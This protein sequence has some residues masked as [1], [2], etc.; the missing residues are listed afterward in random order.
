M[1]LSRA[2]V[3]ALMILA[4]TAN[5]AAATGGRVTPDAV[6]YDPGFP[7]EQVPPALPSPYLTP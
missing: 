2:I 3:M 5:V 4:L 7:G 1:R 6:P